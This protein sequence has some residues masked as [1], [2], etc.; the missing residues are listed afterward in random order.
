MALTIKLTNKNQ[1]LN[2]INKSIIKQEKYTKKQILKAALNTTRYAKQNCPVDMGRLRSSIHYKI[3]NNGYGAYV[4]AATNYAVFVEYGTGRFALNGNGRTTRWMFYSPRYG[5]RYTVGQR[6]SLF[7][8]KAWEKEKP[9][10]LAR[11]SKGG[12]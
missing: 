4:E 12:I 5:W 7:M 1:V 2:A 9:D 3:T 10:F 6:P 11:L 8:T